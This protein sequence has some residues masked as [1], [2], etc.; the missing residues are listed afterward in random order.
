MNKIAPFLTSRKG[1]IPLYLVFLG[2][3]AGASGSRLRAHSQYNNYVYLAEGWLHGRLS[4][5]GP[6]PNENDWG[7][8]EVLNLRDGTTLKG[9]FSKRMPDRFTPLKGTPR[10]ITPDQ[11]ASRSNLRYVTFPPFPA[12]LMLPIVAISGLSTN[13]VIFT[14][15]LAA[16]APVLFLGLLREL[17]KRGYSRRTP[18]D[19][20]W[21]MF[22][23]GLG[24]VFYY[25][26]V[27]GQVWYTAH[28]VAVLIG[29]LFVRSALDARR[30]VTA[31]L[32]LGLGM[33]TRPPLGFM[34]I[35]FVLESLRVLGGPK[36]AIRKPQNRVRLVALLLRF[37]LAASAIAAVMVV[38]NYV[39]FQS[40]SVFGHEYLNIAWAQRI[41]RW[42]LFNYHFLSRNLTAALLLTPQVFKN[43]PY[44]KVSSH[45]LSLLITSPFLIY[46][47]LPRERSP[48]RPSLWWTI[49]GVALLPL[50][51]QNSGY[52]QFGYRFSLDYMVFLMTL[53]AVE[54][55]PLSRVFKAMVI[56]AIAINLFGAIT[57]DRFGEFRYEGFFPHGSD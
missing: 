18:E 56:I 32:L 46:C 8:I 25:A 41:E 13:D 31:G 26:S 2:A 53:I 12:V 3:F 10:T 15:C 51:Y 23:F 52:I 6:P 33:A 7:L 54:G 9:T 36:E 20:L 39:R 50:L 19:D 42:G 14:I 34:C 55:R 57:F 22:A 45:G 43:Y 49:G 11:I 44:V 37:G 40:L 16:C 27:L 17:V 35:F 47:V 29:I 38:H 48:L 28:I 1:L 5:A 21:L 24:S 30:P 4:L